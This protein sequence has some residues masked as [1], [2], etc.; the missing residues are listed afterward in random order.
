MEKEKI[1]IRILPN[2]FLRLNGT[3]NK[4]RA[5][6]LCG[7]IA[8]ECYDEEGFDRINHEP[9]K[10]T[11]AR[12]NRTLDSQHFSVYDHIYVSFELKKIPKILAMVL[13]NEHQYTTAEKSARYT[14]VKR[15][16]KS[17]I[18]EDEERLYN[19]WLD[20]FKIKI[21]SQYGKVYSDGKIRTLAQENARYL[22]SV[23]MPTQMVYST[24][25]RQI[26]CIASWMQDYI[27]KAD[28]NNYFEKQL[29]FYMQKLLTSFDDANFLEERLMKN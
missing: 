1:K 14:K 26:N 3:F 29:S 21:K 12:I 19:K 22:V 27:E 25:L 20:I 8:G 4:K 2:K 13:N 7:K 5:L 9:K 17:I 16:E 24:T 15:E 11:I 23:F 18:T 28:M 10:K 6:R